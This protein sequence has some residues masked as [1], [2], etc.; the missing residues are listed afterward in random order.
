MKDLSSGDKYPK[1]ME[2]LILEVGFAS[3]FNLHV[4]LVQMADYPDR[5]YSNC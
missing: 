1:T 2:N 4:Q 5:Y 3:F